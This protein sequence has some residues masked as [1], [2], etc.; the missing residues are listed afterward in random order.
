MDTDTG[1]GKRTGVVPTVS[2]GRGY[3]RCQ[4]IEI[5]T[6][7]IAQ[8]LLMRWNLK[9]DSPQTKQSRKS[10]PGEDDYGVGQASLNR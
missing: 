4:C 8:N 2:N 6:F 7:C 5:R 9:M 1:E 10:L 3:S